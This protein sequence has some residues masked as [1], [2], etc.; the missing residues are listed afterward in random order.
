M[1]LARDDEEKG[2]HAEDDFDILEDD[3]LASTAPVK[4]TRSRHWLLRLYSPGPNYTSKVRHDTAWINGLRGLAALLIL[5]SSW[6]ELVQFDR[7]GT[8]GSVMAN[9]EEPKAMLQ[10]YRLPIVR[11]LYASQD[12]VISLFF[13]ISG[14]VLSQPFLQLIRRGEPTL[15]V[16]GLASATFRR[17]L[18]L[19]I[20][21]TI[22]FF[23]GFVLVIAGLRDGPAFPYY[24]D[25][26]ES[27][28]G[29]ELSWFLS[30]RMLRLTPHLLLNAFEP[31]EANPIVAGLPRF[32]IT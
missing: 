4:T 30:D 19:W 23:T 27:S 17:C 2:E 29:H 15:V 20:P 14:Y 10:W 3:P 21:S 11:W 16:N 25:M 9:A 18:R 5:S 24:T 1:H 7:V 22:A 28:F 13:I 12:A 26:K 31:G 6:H 8:F 32:E